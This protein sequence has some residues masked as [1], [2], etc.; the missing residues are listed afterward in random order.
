MCVYPPVPHAY[1]SRMAYRDQRSVFVMLTHGSCP[2]YTALPGALFK[3]LLIV[4]GFDPFRL[5]FHGFS[6]F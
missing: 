4:L 1:A 5:D 3:P 2:H 6:L